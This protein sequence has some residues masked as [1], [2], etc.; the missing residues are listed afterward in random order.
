[1]STDILQEK[2]APVLDHGDLDK[3]DSREK[4]AVVA[5]VLENTERALQEEAS[6]SEASLSG[7][8]FGGAG[9]GELGVDQ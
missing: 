1:M 3:I 7:A 4:K 5:Q 8:G 9:R 6:I 2:W